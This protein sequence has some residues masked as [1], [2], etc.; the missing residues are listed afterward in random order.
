MLVLKRE[1]AKWADAARAYKVFIDGAKAGVI[2]NGET[3][4][5]ELSEGFHTLQ[6]KI[7]WC[8]SGV[9]RFY[10]KNGETI[11]AACSPAKK[12]G[13][14]GDL[15]YIT[16]MCRRYIDLKIMPENTAGGF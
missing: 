5:Y 6:L 1:A 7:D 2:K 11:Y 14:F 16:V 9:A 10:I 3:Q 8:S 15:V 12:P 4:E 13:L